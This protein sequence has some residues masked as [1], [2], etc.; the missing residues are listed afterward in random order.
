MT[1]GPTIQ[2]EVVTPDGSRLAE[3][4]LGLTAPGIE[5]ELGILPGHRP[6]LAA[7]K[8]G[9]VIYE[10]D[11]E[12]QRVAV[13]SGFVEFF[14]D[15]A[16]VLTD[17][18]LRRQDVDAVRARLELKES[19]QALEHFEGDPTSPEYATLVSR[20]LWAAAELELHGDPP[21]PIVRSLAEFEA[22]PVEDYGSRKSQEPEKEGAASSEEH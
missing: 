19:D 5:G 9:I 17:R 6:L 21:P 22:H 2:L 15:R 14:Q 10:V 16:V 1:A 11:G 3:Q 13:G 7:L 12:T 4:V 18:F 20:E 8:T